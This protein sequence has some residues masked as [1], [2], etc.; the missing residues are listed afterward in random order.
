V[1]AAGVTAGAA[2]TVLLAREHIAAD[3]PLMIAN[4]DQW[5]NYSIDAYLAAFDTT[6]WTGF[7]MTMRASSPKW[8]YVQ[9][10]RMERIV[11]VVEKRVVSS[12][13]TVG[14]YSF[15]RGAD[16]VQA[17]ESM[18]ADDDRSQGEFYV[19]P[20]FTRL[21]RAGGAVESL[22]IGT[23]RDGMYGLGTPEDLRWFQSQTRFRQLISG[24]LGL[25]ERAA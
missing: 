21:I 16:F 5:I 8:S 10:D 19:A 7:M 12:E 11:G 14:I 13:A 4:C 18:I 24:E 22:S 15:A 25:A 3:E 9:R 17:A 2:C 6:R 23:D 20:T 1:S